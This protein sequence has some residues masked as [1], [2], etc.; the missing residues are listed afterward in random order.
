[1]VR[2]IAEQNVMA[3][4]AWDREERIGPPRTEN[5]ANTESAPAR[6]RPS[7]LLTTSTGDAQRTDEVVAPARSRRQ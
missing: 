3:V 5:R 6:E 2:K 7:V 4:A 1:V